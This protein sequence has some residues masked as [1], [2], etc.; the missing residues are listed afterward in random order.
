[1][2][3]HWFEPNGRR[4]GRCGQQAGADSARCRAGPD[5]A[6]PAPAPG[7]GRRPADR[8]EPERVPHG[9]V[10]CR[11][12]E[13]LEQAQDLDEL[14]LA[15]GAA[16]LRAQ[17]GLE[18]P[19]Q[20]RELRRQLPSLEWRRLVQR[21]DLLLQERQVV[22]RIE[23]EVGA[24]V[25]SAM[26]GDLLAACGDH[27]LVDVALHDDLAMGV[28]DRH[29]VVV[30]AIPHERLA[31]DPARPL[32]AGVERRRRQLHE[33][34]PVLLQARGDRPALTTEHR[35]LTRRAALPQRRV[36]L[37][38]VAGPRDR[39]HERPAGEA[40]H[41]LHG[42]VRHWAR[43]NG[44]FNGSLVP[45]RRPAVPVVEEVVGL[46]RGEEMA[47]LARPVPEDLRHRQLGIVVQD[48]L[49][50]I[51]ATVPRSIPNRRAASLWLRPSRITMRRTR[52]YRST[53]YI[54]LPP[55]HFDPETYRWRDFTPPARADPGRQR[56]RLLRRHSQ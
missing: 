52:P 34:R 54:L 12:R 37:V 44:A 9:G 7:A 17:P 50:T 51:F 16:V 47:A 6:P 39:N 8:A 23:D 26:P 38:D 19:A 46:Q 45:L 36:Q 49:R 18:Q 48:R 21:P 33:R 35:L 1:M 2:Q 22:Q 28:G 13:G 56:G 53:P 31:R 4:F 43:T 42:A 55:D 3:A 20:G 25:R 11:H 14:A 30:V 32:I 40:D 10:D 41:A 15:G 29:R 24:P 5:A 27:H